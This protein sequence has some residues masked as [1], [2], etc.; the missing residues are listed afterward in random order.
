MHVVRAFRDPAVPHPSGAVDP[1]R[2]A[3]AMEEIGA[4]RARGH[5]AAQVEP[6]GQPCVGAGTIVQLVVMRLTTVPVSGR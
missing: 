4:E 2:D 6:H 5:R 1:S 3:Q